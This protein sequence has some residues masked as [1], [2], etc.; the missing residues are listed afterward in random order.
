LINN[1]EKREE[2]AKNLADFSKDDAAE[3]IAD[4]VIRTAKH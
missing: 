4:I 3:R 2:Y 1:A